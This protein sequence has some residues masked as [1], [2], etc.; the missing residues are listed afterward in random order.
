MIQHGTVTKIAQYDA[1]TDDV[2]HIVNFDRLT[3]PGGKN[4]KPS[5]EPDCGW[6]NE[7]CRDRTRKNNSM[8]ILFGM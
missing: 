1:S 4:E 6:D 7:R 3:W 5:G 8:H 2:K